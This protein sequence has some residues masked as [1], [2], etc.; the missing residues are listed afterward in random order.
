MYLFSHKDGWS[1][2]KDYPFTGETEDLTE[3]LTAAGYAK[4]T[5]YEHEEINLELAIYAGIK[6]DLKY[7][8]IAEITL[9]DLVYYV[10]LPE[11][12]DLLSFLSE[13]TLV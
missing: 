4:Q 2:V 8:F 1:K 6:N 5:E 10:A 12:P 11:L 9:G 3:A 7:D 13:F